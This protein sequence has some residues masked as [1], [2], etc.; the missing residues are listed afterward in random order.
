MKVSRNNKSSHQ[1][2]EE[3]RRTPKSSAFMK[4]SK[5]STFP[6][7][8]TEDGREDYLPRSSKIPI[9]KMFKNNLT[10]CQALDKG[11][12]KLASASIKESKASTGALA[13][14][15]DGCKEIGLQNRKVPATKTPAKD[16]RDTGIRSTKIPVM[17]VS[18]NN[19]SSH[20]TLEQKRRAPKSSAFIKGPNASPF[21]LSSKEDGCEDF[22]PRSSKIPV[23]KRFKNNLT[24]CQALDKMRRKLESASI[25]ESKASTGPLASRS[26]GCKEIGLQCSKV[27]ARKVPKNNLNVQQAQG[28]QRDKSKPLASDKE[29][30]ATTENPLP[31]TKGRGEDTGLQCRKIPVQKVSKMKSRQYSEEQPRTAKSLPTVKE[32]LPCSRP[33]SSTK[34][35]TGDVQNSKIPAQKVLKRNLN[36]HQGLEKQRPVLKSSV[37][38]KESNAS[39][40]RSSPGQKNSNKPRNSVKRPTKAN[41][42]KNPVRRQTTSNKNTSTTNQAIA[43]SSRIIFV[44]ILR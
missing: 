3:K 29:S 2:L 19:K 13:S 40:S 42:S 33:L 11:R 18:R 32:S 7:S 43:V 38:V 5:A 44:G 8:S 4:G 20:H 35:G 34:D 22:L 24:S 14:T 41:K 10:S 28:A 21:P 15:S 36:S 27:P 30:K 23:G 37:S 9:G 31:A 6:L 1:A 26:D 12:H 17:N 39:T 16:R 25:K